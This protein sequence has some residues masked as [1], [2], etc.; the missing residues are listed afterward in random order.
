[1]SAATMPRRLT[2]RVILYG[3]LTGAAASIFTAIK[4]TGTAY[5]SFSG[6]MAQV[7]ETVAKVERLERWREV[8]DERTYN[9]E[10]WMSRM[11]EK[12]GVPAPPPRRRRGQ[13]AP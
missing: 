6:A 3:A 2:D 7:P 12:M 13:E 5:A 8:Q 11:G 4:W 10:W 1:M 9:I